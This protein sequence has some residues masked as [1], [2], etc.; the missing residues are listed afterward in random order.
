MWVFVVEGTTVDVGEGV[1]LGGGVR[2]GS[3]VTVFVADSV[4]V[5]L[6][7]FS[8]LGLVSNT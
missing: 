8:M 4:I 7:A 6:V 2:D 3:F 1:R 5:C